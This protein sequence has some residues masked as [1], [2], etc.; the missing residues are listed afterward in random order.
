[1]ISCYI[2]FKITNIVPNK[3]IFACNHVF[4]LIMFMLLIHIGQYLVLGLSGTA[5][6]SSSRVGDMG[7]NTNTSPSRTMNRSL[8]IQNNVDVDKISGI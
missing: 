7:N 3:R 8:Q 6:R 4:I 5:D 2:D 1:M